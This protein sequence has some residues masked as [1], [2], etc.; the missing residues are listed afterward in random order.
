LRA[1]FRAERRNLD[2]VIRQHHDQRINQAI[3]DLVAQARANPIFM[4]LPDSASNP[5]S[6]SAYLSF[7]GEPDVRP[8]L[9]ILVRQGI[10]VVVPAIATISGTRQ[11][12]FREWTPEHPLAQSALGIDQPDES[13][14]VPVRDLDIMLMPLV[15]WDEHGHRLGMGAGYYDRTLADLAGSRRPL[16]IGVAYAVQKFPGLPADPWDVRLHEVITDEG[17]FTC[18][19]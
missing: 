10:R 7:D 2:T 18:V 14:A 17:R 8:A 15:A 16:R 6:I 11:L 13:G 1:R 19:T 12:E 4:G 9:G 3:L 5:F